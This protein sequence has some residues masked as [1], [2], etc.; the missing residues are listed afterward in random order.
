MLW[1][2]LYRSIL[3]VFL[4]KKVHNLLFIF[5]IGAVF[6]LIC[7]PTELIFLKFILLYFPLLLTF[8]LQS[9]LIVMWREK[10]Y[11]QFEFFLNSLIS[12][13]KI[14]TGFRAGFKKSID[15]LPH[16]VFQNY[17][18]EIWDTIFLSKSIRKEF[19]YPPLRQI[20]EELKRIDHSSSCLEHLENLRHQT[21][22]RSLFRKKV[23]SALLQIRIQA[24]ILL[25]L[26]SGLFLFILQRYGL[27]YIKILFLSLF[28]FIL[29]LIILYYCGRRIKWTI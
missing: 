22:V 19:H 23:R 1:N 10:F 21:K 8:L 26:Y 20:I 25:V 11:L 15:R 6:F 2:R 14:G 18:R 9:I 4:P 5:G 3:T 13:V 12:Q 28:C 24:F 17:F 16:P 27:K 29:G 7:L